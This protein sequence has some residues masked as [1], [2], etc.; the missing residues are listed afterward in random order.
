M[1]Q[2]VVLLCTC[3]CLQGASESNN[4]H[5]H[6]YAAHGVKSL[7]H[8]YREHLSSVTVTLTYML[9]LSLGHFWNTDVETLS[10]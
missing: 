6:L 4:H 1:E 9:P 5:T 3:D 2:C 8:Y 10:F 7:G